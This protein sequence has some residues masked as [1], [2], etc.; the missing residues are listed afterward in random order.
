MR[1]EKWQNSLFISIS[2]E[3]DR[4]SYKVVL[5]FI[6]CLLLDSVTIFLVYHII[7]NK[8]ILN[9]KP[10]RINNNVLV[11]KRVSFKKDIIFH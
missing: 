3:S 8:Y 11:K 6:L 9:I 4:M 1:S 10:E 5:G 7:F 2:K